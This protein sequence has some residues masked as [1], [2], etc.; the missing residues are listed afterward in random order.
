[1]LF[2]ETA[3]CI[4]VKELVIH[5]RSVFNAKLKVQL[6]PMTDL[7][8]CEEYAVV[9]TATIASAVEKFITGNGFGFRTSC[10]TA[11]V[12]TGKRGGP[13]ILLRDKQ[14]TATAF[15]CSQA[16]GIHCQVHKLNP[17]TDQGATAF[18]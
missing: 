3:D 16:V 13:A 12:T 2:D 1:M 6:P 17:A 8:G 7:L 15:L 18:P 4:T 10:S 9:L 14:K 5:F 11:L